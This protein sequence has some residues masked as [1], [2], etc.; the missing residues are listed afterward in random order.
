M[1]Q[2]RQIKQLRILSCE[3]VPPP[4]L[5]PLCLGS[6][7]SQ[8]DVPSE[9]RRFLA[10]S[11]WQPAGCFPSSF[12]LSFIIKQRTAPNKGFLLKRFTKTF[13]CAFPA[14]GFLCR[15]HFSPL[16]FLLSFLLFAVSSPCFLLLHKAKLRSNADTPVCDVRA[17]RGV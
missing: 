1:F 7:A 4:R 13:I 15:F 16:I 3:R 12:A 2:S 14:F 17:S 5:A 8:R 9:G 11:C 10:S 6:A